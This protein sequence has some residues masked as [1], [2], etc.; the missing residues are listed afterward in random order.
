MYY[1]VQ[2]PIVLKSRLF[3]WNYSRQKR[4]GSRGD[5]HQCNRLRVVQEFS[6]RPD[7]RKASEEGNKNENE[8]VGRKEKEKEGKE[9]Q[10]LA[11]SR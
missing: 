5:Q 7:K 9:W 2:P 11:L 8:E 6:G 4:W 10:R 3:A 1:Y